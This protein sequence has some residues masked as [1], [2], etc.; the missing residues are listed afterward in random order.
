MFLLLLVIDEASLQLSNISFRHLCKFNRE[1]SLNTTMMCA[2]VAVDNSYTS[3]LDYAESCAVLR[4]SKARWR[5]SV[6]QCA[7]RYAK[8]FPSTFTITE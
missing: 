8:T 2:F 7:F 4:L 6:M 1:V 5:L 3:R